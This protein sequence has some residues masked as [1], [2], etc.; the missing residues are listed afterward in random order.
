MGVIA[1][2]PKEARVIDFEPVRDWP[3]LLLVETPVNV[4]LL[5]VLVLD[6]RITSN[7]CAKPWPA[8]IGSTS[9]DT[10]GD[11]IGERLGGSSLGVH[12]SR[13]TRRSL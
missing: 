9:V 2:G 4:P 1:T 12:G 13:L 10:K 7:R 11:T 6:D 5:T 8:F 3:D